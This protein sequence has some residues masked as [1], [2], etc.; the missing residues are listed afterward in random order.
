MIENVENSVFIY[1][2]L[3][4]GEIEKIEVIR[5]LQTFTY[6]IVLECAKKT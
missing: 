4:L 2:S 6:K 1:I 3:K 5:K